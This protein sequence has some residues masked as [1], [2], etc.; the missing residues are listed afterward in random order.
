MLRWLITAKRETDVM[1]SPRA[2]SVFASSGDRGRGPLVSA[3][4]LVLPDV[5]ELPAERGVTVDHATVHR[6]VQRFTPKFFEAA[7]LGR[8]EQS[9]HLLAE[10]FDLL[11]S[12]SVS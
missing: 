10:T 4:R 7:R 12:A 6:W 9:G 1:T 2:S 5:E 8:H 11:R 3:V